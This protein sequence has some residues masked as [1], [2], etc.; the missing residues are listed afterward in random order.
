MKKICC[1]LICMWMVFT[2]AACG[3]R[4]VS[5]TLYKEDTTSQQQQSSASSSAPAETN[6]FASATQASE[7]S[8]YFCWV[9]ELGA[10][11]PVITPIPDIDVEKFNALAEFYERNA[12]DAVG[13]NIGVDTRRIPYTARL[14]PEIRFGLE[15]SDGVALKGAAGLHIWEG[16]LVLEWYTSGDDYMVAVDVPDDLSHYFIGIVNALALD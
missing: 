16:K 9:M 11:D 5:S 8:A 10:E 13:S 7:K 12:Y 1:G 2:F 14:E 3:K 4:E 6:S 15:E